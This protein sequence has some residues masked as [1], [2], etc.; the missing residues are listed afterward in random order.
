MKKI[1]L[2]FRIENIFAGFARV[3]GIIR[4]EGDSVEIEFQAMDNLVRMIKSNIKSLSVP[5]TDIEEI[6]FNKSIWGNKLILRTSKL[7]AI[8]EVP[9]QEACEIKLSI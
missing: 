9:N 6:Y 4:L 1:S 2:P 5:V 3:N 7:T 8:S